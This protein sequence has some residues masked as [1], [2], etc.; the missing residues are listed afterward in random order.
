MSKKDECKALKDCERI[1]LLK[2][3]PF[4]SAVEEF[5]LYCDHKAYYAT[6]VS[7]SMKKKIL[8]RQIHFY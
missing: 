8:L 4:H 6:V 2:E 3:P 7:D 1:T 5:G